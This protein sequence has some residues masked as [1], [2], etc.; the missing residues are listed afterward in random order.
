RIE[1][2]LLGVLAVFRLVL[3]WVLF[4]G[5]L[6]R[7]Q[8]QLALRDE[9]LQR[10]LGGGA[11]AHG[12]GEP[13]QR[14]PQPHLPI[15]EDLDEAEPGQPAQRLPDLGPHRLLR[16]PLV[17]AALLGVEEAQQ[18]LGAHEPRQVTEQLIAADEPP[19]LD[20]RR[21]E[22]QQGER[23]PHEHFSRREVPSPQPVS[24]G[25]QIEEPIRAV[26]Q[27]TSVAPIERLEVRLRVDQERVQGARVP[28]DVLAAPQRQIQIGEL[29][30]EHDVLEAR[31]AGGVHVPSSD[32]EGSSTGGT[33]HS[34]TSM[35]SRT[36]TQG[37]SGSASGTHTAATAWAMR[38]ALA[39]RRSGS[40]SAVSWA[41]TS[42]SPRAPPATIPR[43][44]ASRIA[45]G[46][47]AGSA[48]GGISRS[49]RGR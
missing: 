29:V 4:F 34:S 40:I 37:R 26:D 10:Q 1:G 14:G 30:R 33:R 8:D 42:T 22:I 41:V 36:G 38:P 47:S 11:A 31:E 16:D 48:A 15:G 25:Q 13:H 6:Q 32:A 39:K 19:L 2:R 7:R 24:G 28:V 3:S 9:A 21:I 17:E 23:L 12:L 18:G 35:S 20:G 45:W 43:T 27:L 49:L 46:S 44:R 5:L